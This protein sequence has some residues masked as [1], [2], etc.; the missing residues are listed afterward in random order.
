[1][2]GFTSADLLGLLPALDTLLLLLNLLPFLKNGTKL[3]T[4]LASRLLPPL[5]ALGVRL[6]RRL[7]TR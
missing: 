2:I 3:Q 6:A 1:M 7:S 4:A 5:Q